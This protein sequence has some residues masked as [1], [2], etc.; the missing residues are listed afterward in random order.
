MENTYRIVLREVKYNILNGFVYLL[1]LGVYISTIIATFGRSLVHMYGFWGEHETY[2]Y[3]AHSE[4]IPGVQNP[5]PND[6]I[7]PLLVYFNWYKFGLVL[8]SFGAAISITSLSILLYQLAPFGWCV[9]FRCSKYLKK[10]RKRR[11]LLVALIFI[12]ILMLYMGYTISWSTNSSQACMRKQLQYWENGRTFAPGGDPQCCSS[13]AELEKIKV[14]LVSTSPTPKERSVPNLSDDCKCVSEC[15]REFEMIMPSEDNRIMFN[16]RSHYN[17]HT[18]IE[19]LRVDYRQ[20]PKCQVKSSCMF[21]DV[22]IDSIDNKHYRPCNTTEYV[23]SQSF[24]IRSKFVG[25]WCI[26]WP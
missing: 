21:D 18:L 12:F 10:T 17:S 26:S 9:C 1:I 16:S 19:A 3:W 8:L 15:P 24:R 7:P 20:L 4:I 13:Y 11:Y 2:P 14:K 6:R 22:T 25:E 5:T 23:D